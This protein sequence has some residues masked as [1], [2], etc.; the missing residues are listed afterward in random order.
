MVYRENLEGDPDVNPGEVKPRGRPR[1]F[2]VL[3]K[4]RSRYY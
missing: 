1:G 2:F 4:V 3:V